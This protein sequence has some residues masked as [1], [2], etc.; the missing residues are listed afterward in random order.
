MTIKSTVE[1]RMRDCRPDA[2]QDHV[3]STSS[4]DQPSPPKPRG[5]TA[6]RGKRQWP[7]TT[8]TRRRRRLGSRRSDPARPF[9]SEWKRP[10]EPG[11]AGPRPLR[12]MRR[13]EPQ[14]PWERLRPHPDPVA[15]CLSRR[16]ATAEEARAGAGRGRA[17][18]QCLPLTDC[19][20]QAGVRLSGA[21]GPVI[22]PRDCQEASA[23][24]SAGRSVPRR[25]ARTPTP[26]RP[27]PHPRC[28]HP[29]I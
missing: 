7:Q 15:R 27:R 13:A 19:N 25:T 2:R 4:D 1:I 21:A 29:Q 22:P 3:P 6:R 12:R 18:G 10:M 28:R 24:G 8:R 23:A 11:P 14:R 5:L 26:S 16:G 17:V 9:R 20:R